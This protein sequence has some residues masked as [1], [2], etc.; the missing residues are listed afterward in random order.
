MSK[1][2]P[3]KAEGRRISSAYAFMLGLSS[4]WG[5]YSI[6]TV[7]ALLPLMFLLPA[8]AWFISR[9]PKDP[10]RGL[11]KENGRL[12]LFNQC[13]ITLLAYM[14]LISPYACISWRRA[15]SITAR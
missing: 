9:R 13:L 14:M 5:P 3:N 4:K 2:P 10:L 7:L 12:S 1:T 8:L 6:R 11:R 15:L